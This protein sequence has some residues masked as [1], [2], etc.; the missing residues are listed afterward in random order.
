MAKRGR[1]G[2][3]FAVLSVD[4]STKACRDAVDSPGK[5]AVDG[6]L[7]LSC[8]LIKELTCRSLVHY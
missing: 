8:Y 3:G 6:V 2:G 1:K 5:L 4:A 7:P